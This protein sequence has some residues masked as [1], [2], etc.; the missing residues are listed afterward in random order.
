MVG[1][2]L[3]NLATLT[4]AT[5]IVL[6]RWLRDD[7]GPLTLTAFRFFIAS[8]FYVALLQQQPK[9]TRHLKRDQWPLIV[10]ALSGIVGFSPALYLGLRF[11]TAVN[12]TLITGLGPLITCALAALLIQDPMSKRQIGGAILGLVGVTTLISDGSM[13][14]WQSV[15]N[16][17]GDLIVLGAVALWA[18]Y[19]VLAR[20]VMQ[21]RSALSATS[22]ST[23][24]GLPLLLLAAAWEIRH[25]PVDVKL[26]IA[27]TVLYIGAAPTVIGF[28]SWNAG[29]RR[30]GASGAMVFYNTLPLYGALLGYVFLGES[31][32]LLHLLGGGL[33]IVGGVWAA[34]GD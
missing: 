6:G 15:G 4:W 32:G 11:T 23:F 17:V 3:V 22:L 8:L 14:F 31:I 18:L 26:G 2:G 21:H 5:N 25:F 12:A 28:L 9:A 19:S 13:T 10:M 24:F 33:I 16:N 34:R 20:Q 30:L 1:I 29:I 27:L 7:I